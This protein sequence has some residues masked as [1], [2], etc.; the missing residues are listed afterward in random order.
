M[1]FSDTLEEA[2]FRA[3][4]KGWLAENAP[5]R[6]ELEPLD[7]V[8]QAKLWQKR[9]F[10]AGWACIAWPS[11][12]GGRD[13]SPIEEVIW[14]QEE[15]RYPHLNFSLTFSVGLGL[16]GPTL[17]TWADDAAKSRFLKPLASG[18]EIWCQLF[19]EPVAGS[20][21]AGLRTKALQDDDDWVVN[22]QKVWTSGAQHSD[23]GILLARTDAT[24]PKH[25]GLTY[26]F[27]DMQSPGIEV[28]PIKQINGQSH[29]NEVFFA[30]VRVSDSQR[31]GKVGEGWKVA[32]T[33]LMNERAAI[34]RG[35]ETGF[36]SLFAL[37]R[38]MLI[39][40]EPALNDRSVRA[41]L[42]DWYCDDAGLRNTLM[43]SLS[44]LS[45]GKTPGPEYSIGK[46]VAASMR[47]QVTSYAMDLMD[48][49]GLQLGDEDFAFPESYLD[50]PSA[51]I[52]GGTD[53]ILANIIAER[54]LG[55][56][57]EVRT[58][59]GIPFVDIPTGR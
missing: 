36:E 28:R 11:Q 6:G 22:G 3:E 37:S 55:M 59:K 43:R 8:A 32:L 17:M 47:Q 7:L 19:S 39:D 23:F 21:L 35:S 58:D 14:Q 44:L 51:R 33:T 26:F 4:V 1:D 54:V 27:V 46:L 20:D 40:G 30:D 49:A 52:A 12:F 31:L 34:G 56:P 38:R 5:T 42:A 29:F 25:Q 53:E 45:Q 16:V 10:D 2:K 50:V 13:A 57:Q 18:A 24:V 9:K 48:L 41:R 15:S